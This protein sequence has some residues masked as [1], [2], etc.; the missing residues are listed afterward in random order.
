[1]TLP[2]AIAAYLL[3][4]PDLAAVVGSRVFALYFPQDP[5]YPAIVFRR[6]NLSYEETLR[7]APGGRIWTTT[8]Y[9]FAAYADRNEFHKAYVASRRLAAALEAFS[10]EQP[11][12]GPAGVFIHHMR[13]QDMGDTLESSE[14]Y[15]QLSADS[16]ACQVPLDF[17]I[18]YDPASETF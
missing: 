4:D 7:K 5:V 14:Q 15:V 9:R 1:M 3:A 8:V 6:V 10:P 16:G 11:I 18:A 12:G 13:P 17:E 2:Q